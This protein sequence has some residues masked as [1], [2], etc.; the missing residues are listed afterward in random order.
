MHGP[1]SA[2]GQS[3]TNTGLS[4]TKEEQGHLKHNNRAGQVVV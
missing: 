4:V 1:S 3:D 2:H